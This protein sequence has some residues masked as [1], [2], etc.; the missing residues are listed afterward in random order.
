MLWNVWGKPCVQFV[1]RVGVS[2]IRPAAR[3]RTLRNDDFLEFLRLQVVEEP[4]R[5]RGNRL[6]IP[7][8]V[9]ISLGISH[10]CC[11]L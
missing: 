9:W 10:I 1:N 2:R 4:V 6:L 8:T 5:G 3:A 11:V 7:I